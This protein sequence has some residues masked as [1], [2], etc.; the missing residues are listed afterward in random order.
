MKHY[1]WIRLA[2]VAGVL[3]AG[4]CS[5]SETPAEETAAA[6][7][8]ATKPAAAMAN[9]AAEKTEV[10]NPVW[11]DDF[12]A[13][14]AQARE[15]KRPILVDFTGSDWC[16]WCFRLKDEVFSQ[17]AFQ[18]YAGRHL[19]LF[20]ADFPR[21][22]SLPAKVR[23]QNEQLARKYEIQGFPTILL[24]DAE[25]KVLAQTGYQRGGAEAYVKHLQQLLAGKAA[26]AAP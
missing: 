4:A 8:A 22:K 23:E 6:A 7:A 19:V 14:Q 5:R 3:G 25:G 17:A 26:A 10:I 18:Q 1:A 9:A 12:A 2:V 11:L 15:L 20:I 16:G 21:N 24:L 13:A